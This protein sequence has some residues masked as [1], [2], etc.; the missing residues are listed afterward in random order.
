[1]FYRQTS[2]ISVL[3]FAAAVFLLSAAASFFTGNYRTWPA[4]GRVLPLFGTGEA[5]MV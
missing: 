3:R 2:S 5:A 1:M 4:A